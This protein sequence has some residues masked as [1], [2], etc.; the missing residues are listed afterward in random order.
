MTRTIETTGKTVEHATK[1]A[2]RE[3]GIKREDAEV[4]VV[5]QGKK[6]LLGIF[7]GTPA[8]VRVTHRPPTRKRAEVIVSEILRLMHISSQL[9][10][11]EE[12]NSL[13]IDIETAGSDGLLIGKGGQ[14][15][16]AM[17]YLANRMLQ[18]EGRRTP[19][20]ILDVSGYKRE[21]EDFLKS[22]ALSLAEQVKSAGQQ[23]TT[24][25]L[26]AADRKIVHETLRSDPAVE[27]KS[28]GHGRVKSVVLSPAKGRSGG[29]KRPRR[30]RRK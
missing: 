30:R 11:T 25:P 20:V 28:V 23:V 9:H 12:K 26:D 2:L 15:L 3:L 19:R 18:R 27:T 6:G 10:V 1:E 17:E 29:R 7:G 8:K 22:K 13:V 16:S 24:E 4:D 14:T 5:Q 21:R